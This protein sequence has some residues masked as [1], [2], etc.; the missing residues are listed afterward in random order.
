MSISSCETFLAGP[1]KLDVLEKKHS[2]EIAVGHNPN[3]RGRAAT[4]SVVNSSTTNSV[5]INLEGLFPSG[6]DITKYS[7]T[8]GTTCYSTIGFK[9]FMKNG[10]L[11]CIKKEVAHITI[12]SSAS[13]CAATVS[14]PKQHIKETFC[15]PNDFI[16]S[17]DSV[18]AMNHIQ[19][20]LLVLAERKGVKV[21][22]KFIQSGA[23]CNVGNWENFYSSFDWLAYP[24]L[25]EIDSNELCKHL[26]HTDRDIMRPNNDALNFKQLIEH[27]YGTS[28]SKMLSEVWKYTTVN[29]GK[30]INQLA[31]IVGPA[32][33]KT[34][35]FDYLYQALPFLDTAESPLVGETH[36]ILSIEDHFSTLLKH[37]TPKK[38]I[39]IVFGGAWMANLHFLYDAVRMLKEF[40]S[41]EKIP[42]ALRE[43]YSRGLTAD[44]KFKTLQEFHDKISVEYTTIKG[45]SSRKLIPVH[46][47]YGQLNGREKNGL[48]LI[49]PQNTT[50]LSVWGKLLSHCVASYG[51]RAAR[52]D[53]MILGVERDGHILYCLELEP[54]IISRMGGELYGRPHFGDNPI[55]EVPIIREPIPMLEKI[56]MTTINGRKSEIW[57][58]YIV[59]FRGKHN[60]E[61]EP[62]DENTVRSML[63][64]WVAENKE[65]YDKH[66]T[67]AFRDRYKY[68]GG[69]P[70]QIIMAP[71]QYE[72]LRA[73][74]G[75]EQ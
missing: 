50:Y 32:V 37:M 52:G 30:G 73:A 18:Q 51:D 16:W 55:E 1:I 25:R 24:L 21:P 40:D 53:T 66:G 12:V 72:A 6:T 45:E 38:L 46:E 49:V 48:K 42:L 43:R 13:V 5:T 71:A 60:A 29:S 63:T 35:G 41:Q 59:Q 39:N 74:L 7:I 8:N 20:K 57:S 44:F 2:I 34:M 26:L 69:V 61:P 58:P 36:N 64:E 75:N 65:E 22:A 67:K 70:D 56:L 15:C 10:V 11:K 4:T 9:F 33:F 3:H 19:A 47:I 54:L 17:F 14:I 62:Y 28:T 23:H 31:F 68:E 27:Y